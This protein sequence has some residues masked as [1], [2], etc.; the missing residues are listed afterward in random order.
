MKKQLTNLTAKCSES[1]I[2]CFSISSS[3]SIVNQKKTSIV[4]LS[5]SEAVFQAIIVKSDDGKNIEEAD[6]TNK[7]RL[8]SN[9]H[10]GEN[11]VGCLNFSSLLV[12]LLVGY[13][14]QLSISGANSLY[15]TIARNISST[16]TMRDIAVFAL[17]CSSFM[18]FS[19]FVV[20]AFLCELI[21]IT[22]RTVPNRRNAN[23]EEIIMQMEIQ[24]LV[25]TG[26]GISFA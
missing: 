5:Q 9:V 16:I 19:P 12:G 4:S 24:F 6:N 23:L 14:F 11:M 1:C 15:I 8:Q 22:Y 18:D 10:F 26:F 7:Q 20:V 25:G 13:I 17:I 3:T 21:A 2:P